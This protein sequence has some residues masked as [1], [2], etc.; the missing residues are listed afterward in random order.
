MAK[1]RTAPTPVGTP[2]NAH[3]EI[4]TEWRH[5]GRTVEPGTELKIQ[6]EPGRFRFVK[7]VHNP[8]NGAV[9]VDVIGGPVK[10]EMFRSFAPERVKTVHKTRNTGPAL[11]ERHKQSKSVRRAV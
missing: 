2:A 1:R 11:V 3:W 10:V 5:N 7:H 9:W 6:G 4:T 8:V